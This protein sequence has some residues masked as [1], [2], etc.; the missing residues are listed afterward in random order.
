IIV[1]LVLILHQMKFYPTPISRFVFGKRNLYPT[2]DFHNWLF[3]EVSAKN[4]MLLV[5]ISESLH[6][7]SSLICVDNRLGVSEFSLD[8]LKDRVRIRAS[9]NGL[10]CCSSI[11][12]RGVYYVCNPMTREFKLLPKSRERPVTRFYPDG[13]AALVGLACNLSTHKF[14]VVLAGY[15]RNFGHRPDGTFICLVFDSESNKWRKCVS[16]QDDQFTHM[17][18]NQVVF[19]NNGLHW[20]TGR[21]GSGILVLD[22][23]C[24]MWRKMSL[25]YEVSEESG[26]RVY[27]L[28]LD[29]CLSVIQISDTWMN[30]WA[31]KNYEKHEWVLVD[32]V[33]VLCYLPICF[34]KG[35]V[36]AKLR[37][38]LN[39]MARKGNQQK[40]GIDSHAS[41]HKKRSS[42]IGSAEPDVKANGNASEAKEFPGDELP[43][44]NHPNSPLG[45]ST[46]K[47][48]NA[49]GEH[50]SKKKTN[51]HLRKDKQAV[52]GVDGVEQ[53][54]EKPLRN[55]SDDHIGN[56]EGPS[57]VE[58]NVPVPPRAN[59]M[60]RHRKSRTSYSLSGLRIQNALENMELPD[61]VVMRKLKALALSTIK[62]TNEWLERQRPLFIRLK[63][64]AQKANDYGK[65]KI[66]QAY[67]VVLKWLMHFGSIMLL[68]LMVWLDCAIRGMD[69]FLRLGTT[70]FFSVIWCGIFSLIAMVGIFKFLLVLAFAALIGLF[71]GFTLGILVAA[72][73]GAIL[74]WLYGSFWTTLFVIVLGGLAFALSCER[75]ALFISTVY[76]V[77]CA[78]TYVGWFGVLVAFN[79]AFVSSDILIYFLKNNINQSRSAEGSTEQTPGMQGQQGFFN[80]D[81]THSS[82]FETGP[83]FSAD[84][85]PGAPSTSGT[86]SETTSEDEVVR[87]LNCTDLYSVLGLARYENVDVS[88]LKREYRKK[89]M[90]VHPDKNMGNE[91][92]V[93]AFKKLQNAYE[94]LLDAVKR[95]TYDD[96]LR[97][98]ELLDIFRRF[99]STSQKNGG[100]GLFA[101]GMARS[102]ADGEDLFG[103]SRRIACKKCNNFHLWVLTRKSKSQ[104][105]WCQDCNDF[106]QARDGDGWVEQSSQPLIFGLLQKVDAPVAFVCADSKVYNATEWYI[107]QGMRCPANTHKPS[108]HV[109]TSLTTKHSVGK[110]SSSGQKGSKMPA[111]NVEDCMTEEEFFEWFQ[112]AVQSGMFENMNGVNSTNTESPSSEAGNS[113]AK[114]GGSNNSSSN[115]KKK[116]GK[117]W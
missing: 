110:G 68:I 34:E 90:L 5:E 65:T 101:S 26:N 2:L 91:K 98:E 113:S 6:L 42:D 48:H 33:L 32:R 16:Y 52:N 35:S 4:P 93:E 92:A 88:L 51:K 37:I 61:N 108:F 27:L 78:W 81:Q 87:L 49:G 8:F 117:K 74:L 31:L 14:N 54:K 7:K 12:D 47:T 20:L 25:P 40:N 67:P 73:S 83:G 114:S 84:R 66:M 22:L 72:I 10:L 36:K 9:C 21:S 97:R 57:V 95:K 23:E 55:D 58:E 11:P 64:Q 71:V 60:K 105:R 112:N 19:V 106:H 53:P 100:H 50:K 46:G 94:V 77:Y 24:D 59:H 63:N 76:S 17:N 79:L 15:H 28:E 30:I 62:A 102:D 115:K 45:R 107:C 103:E 89:A 56:S 13:E 44:G 82:A 96:E 99:Q 29:G 80:S 3:N 85:S 111:N 116:K 109:N 70:S 38:Y 43:D 86:D 18:K 69:S 75:V 1:P 104:A 41:N 39:V